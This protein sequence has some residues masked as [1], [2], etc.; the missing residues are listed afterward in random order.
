MKLH[1]FYLRKPIKQ[2]SQ[3]LPKAT[4]EAMW[5]LPGSTPDVASGEKGHL[6]RPPAWPASGS[7]LSPIQ[8]SECKGLPASAELLS[9]A[10][11]TNLPWDLLQDWRATRLG[12]SSLHFF[13]RNVEAV[14]L[15][16]TYRGG[17]AKESNDAG[18]QHK[19][20]KRTAHWDVLLVSAF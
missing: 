8:P 9:K 13:H 17:D 7:F 18:S 5:P 15:L 20:R 14:R 19:S 12:K 6:I 3:H 2:T 16:I 4:V 1:I 10:S 11:V